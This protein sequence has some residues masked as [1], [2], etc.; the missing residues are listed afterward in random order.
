MITL[1]RGIMLLILLYTSEQY[2]FYIIIIINIYLHYEKIDEVG[3][4]CHLLLSWMRWTSI[5][6]DFSVAGSKDEW[7]CFIWLDATATTWKRTFD[8]F[9][10]NASIPRSETKFLFF[11]LNVVFPGRNEQKGRRGE[12]KNLTLKQICDI[13]NNP[14]PLI[15]IIRRKKI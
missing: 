8:V 13:E 6:D 15:G 3:N 14:D 12:E 7:S 2:R 11:K 5:W 10:T 9:C 4:V 1:L